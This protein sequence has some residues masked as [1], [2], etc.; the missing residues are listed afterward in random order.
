MSWTSIVL[1]VPMLCSWSFLKFTRLHLWFR[2]SVQ[3]PYW[4]PSWASSV[5]QRQQVDSAQLSAVRAASCVYFSCHQWTVGWW[6]HWHINNVWYG[7]ESLSPFDGHFRWTWVCQY[8]NVSI[9]DFIGANCD[10]GDGD[11]WSYK[12]CIMSPPTSNILQAIYPSC[13]PTNSDKALKGN[14]TAADYDSVQFNTLIY[15]WLCSVNRNLQLL[16]TCSC[17]I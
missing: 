14:D 8:Q 15:C 9:L 2:L 16:S 3:V 17:Y 6:F 4:R 13:C 10:G 7:I 11:S 5:V 12:T 1:F